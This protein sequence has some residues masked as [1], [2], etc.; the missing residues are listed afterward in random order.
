LPGHDLPGAAGV[1]DQARRGSP[2]RIK[3]T[4]RGFPHPSRDG[5]AQAKLALAHAISPQPGQ[6]ELSLPSLGLSGPLER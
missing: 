5:L 3:G 6:P 2:V 1:P 4:L